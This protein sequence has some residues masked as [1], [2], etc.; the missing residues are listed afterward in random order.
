MTKVVAHF[1]RKSTQLKASFIHNQITFHTEYKPVVVNRYESRKDDGGFAQFPADN[2]PTLNLAENKKFDPNYRYFARLSRTDLNRVLHFLDDHKVSVLHFHYGSDACVYSDVMKVS[3]RPSVV[4]FYGY[5]ASSFRTSFAGYG[6]RLLNTRLFPYVTRVLAMSPDMRND[7]L[8]MGCPEDKIVVHYYGSD[9][10]RF[11]LSAER[12]QSSAQTTFLII[13]GLEPQKGH[14]FL[15]EAFKLAYL[16]NNRIR[17]R[18]VGTGSAERRIREF[19]NRNAMNSYV[20]MNGKVG[21]ASPQHLDELRRA[22]VF[23]HPSVTPKN[24]DKEGIPGAILEAMAA[25]LPVIST[26]H[27]GIPYVIRDGL[28]GLL[29]KEWDTP[30]LVESILQL[31]SNT[32]LRKKLGANGQNSVLTSLD[33]RKKEMELEEIYDGLIAS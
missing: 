33:L 23:I 21:Y 20:S 25:G 9:I 4:S 32:E 16:S 22:D 3:G 2:M 29:V 31:A 1:V 15:L 12:R 14:L 13:S 6:R 26:F 19:I 28:T 7:L 30:A 17:L 11:F 18:I 24:G 8:L 27:A 5:D 10:E